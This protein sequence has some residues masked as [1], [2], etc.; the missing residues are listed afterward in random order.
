MLEIDG[1]QL[2]QTGCITRYI[3]RKA[4][5]YGKTNEESALYVNID[6]IVESRMIKRPI[7]II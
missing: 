4:G 5:L 7:H 6:F 3:A 2:V 1:L